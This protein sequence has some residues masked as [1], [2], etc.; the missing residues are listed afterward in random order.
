MGAAKKKVWASVWNQTSDLWIPPSNAQKLFWYFF[1]CGSST[2]ETGV[3]EKLLVSNDLLVLIQQ[4]SNLRFIFLKLLSTF[5]WIL[6][7]LSWGQ[8][9]LYLDDP[10]AASTFFS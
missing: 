5:I 9:V 4:L 10:Y 7:I 8:F 6:I 2:R 1:C 3:V